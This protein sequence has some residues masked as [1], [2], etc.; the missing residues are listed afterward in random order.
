M[1]A[2][3][4]LN[5]LLRLRS[6][7]PAGAGEVTIHGCDPFYR[8]P[9]RAG[10]VTAASLAATGI[11][12][13]DIWE[14][15]TGKRQKIAISVGEAAATLRTTDYTLKRDET[16][17]YR[18]IPISDSMADMHTIT[19]P[20][21]TRDGRW[22]LPHFNLPNLKAR[23]LGVLKCG[24]TPAEVGAAIAGWNADQLEA[25]IA[26]ARACGGK[27]RT[28]AEWL[29]HPHGA[30]LSGR[31]PVEIQR[32][33]DSLPENL[34][35]GGRPLAGVRVL[36]LT[37]ILA[38]PISGRTLAEHGADVLMVSAEGLPQVPEFVRDTSHGKRSCFLDLKQP[39]DARHFAEL[40]RGADVVIDGY[41]PGAIASLGF[42]ARQLAALRPGIVYLSV[43]CFGSGG[44]FADRAGWEQIAQAV[45]GICQTHGQL[46][47]AGQPKLVRA[48][49]C[50]YNTGY[51][52]AYG[53]MLALTRRAREGGSWA[54]RASLCQTAMFIRRQGLREEFSDGP[55]RLADTELNRCYIA[56]E[57][58]Y[59]ALKTLGPV[60]RMSETQP[61][62]AR[63]T[64]RF[65]GDQP[66]W[67]P[68]ESVANTA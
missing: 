9:Y 59:G 5:E 66:E 37:R 44:P 40:V 65:G 3:H 49:M 10:E 15:R 19:Q 36:D 48:T 22:F 2:Q 24:D 61:R 33:G 39:E 46:T 58:S 1:T 50:D 21:P 64:P 68:R 41:R 11:A 63:P 17:V 35:A 51:L 42:G 25:A 4:A 6:A 62:W 26:K 18:T 13:N 12:A 38:G 43:S 14:I 56:A 47:G 54:V 32:I 20:W 28:T 53:V 67:L 29:A 7:A 45:T 31:P 23:V 55:E 27:I 30:Y 16:G 8:T 57:T 60:L 52:A 34:H